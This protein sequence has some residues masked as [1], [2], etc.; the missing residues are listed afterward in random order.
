MVKLSCLAV[1]L[2]DNQKIILPP[3]SLFVFLLFCN[4]LLGHFVAIVTMFSIS[5][6]CQDFVL[7]DNRRKLDFEA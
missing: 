3:G 4:R 1:L 2:S 6:V 7:C 5:I